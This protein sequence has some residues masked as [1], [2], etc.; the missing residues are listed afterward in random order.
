MTLRELKQRVDFILEQRDQYGDIEVCIP[1]G[2]NTMGGT[3]VTPVKIAYRGIDWDS[4]KF[5]IVPETP[6]VEQSKN[7]TE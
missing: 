4:S 3:S 7:D 1:N 5:I 2:K 6:M